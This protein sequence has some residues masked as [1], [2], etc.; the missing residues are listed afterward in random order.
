[1]KLTLPLSSRW[2]RAGVVLLSLPLVGLAC[3]GAGDAGSKPPSQPTAQPT[4]APA[5]ATAQPT[6]TPTSAPAALELPSACSGDPCVPPFPYVK[7]LCSGV[8]PWVALF[9]VRKD[10]GWTH[11]YITSRSSEAFNGLGGPASTEKL[12][13]DEEVVLLA[14]HGPA[15]TG[16]MQVS[17]DQGTYDILRWD[18]SCATVQKGEIS[19]RP[20]P[21]PKNATIAWRD[22]DDTLQSALTE[23]KNLRELN[24]K[25]RSECKGA[26]MGA[27]S[28][29][30]EKA[31]KALHAALVDYVRKGGAI[32]TPPPLKP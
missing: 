27:V 13:F 4:A 9:L 3:G 28:A 19:T 31:D 20:P 26:T 2:R 12:A 30:C 15:A 10:S 5:N 11:G 22:L 16:G 17:G 21:K 8:N 29:T 1:M 32:P 18:G 25:R 7:K 24:S 6:A 23:D 14:F